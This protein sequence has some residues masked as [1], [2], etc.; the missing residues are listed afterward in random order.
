MQNSQLIMYSKRHYLPKSEKGELRKEE[1]EDDRELEPQAMPRVFWFPVFLFFPLLLEGFEEVEFRLLF[2]L[3]PE[4]AERDELRLI[5]FLFS[6]EGEKIN[7]G[8]R[9]CRWRR[10]KLADDSN[11][12][13]KWNLLYPTRSYTWA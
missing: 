8:F 2:D 10:T 13:A 11:E 7:W 3:S 6:G 1:R 12:A 9:W 4:L 5:F